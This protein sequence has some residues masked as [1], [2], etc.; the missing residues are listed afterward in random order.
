MIVVYCVCHAQYVHTLYRKASVVF[1]GKA[2][3]LWKLQVQYYCF[4]QRVRNVIL[5][6]ILSHQAAE[7][8]VTSHERLTVSITKARCKKVL[9]TYHYEYHNSLLP[10][11]TLS[12]D[13]KIPSYVVV[14]LPCD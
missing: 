10:V 4:R 6:Y 2:D 8:R 12:P 7:F 13:A 3:A 14:G 1:I 11:V 9:R 5:A